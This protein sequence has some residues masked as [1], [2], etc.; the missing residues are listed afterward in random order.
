M[1]FILTFFLTILCLAS[2]LYGFIL[3]VDPYNKFGYNLFGFETKAVDFARQNKFIQVEHSKVPYTAF[4]M[5]SSSAH[6]YLTQ[7]INRLTGLVSYNYSTQSATPEDYISMTR[8]ILTKY[9]PK[10]LLLSMDFEV[11]NKNTK[12]DD[13]FF[14]SPLKKFLSEVPQEDL[15]TD[16]FNNTYFTT[17]AIIDSFKV[18]WVNL[19]GQAN[20][21]YLD[22][23]DHVV[24]PIPKVLKI[25][26]FSFPDYTIDERRV[27]YLKKIVELGAKHGFKVIAFTSPVSYDHIQRLNANPTLKTKHAE[28]KRKLAEIFGEVYD[29]QNEGIKKYNSLQ[30]FRDNNHPTHN[31]ST[32]VLERIFGKEDQENPDFGKLIKK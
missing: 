26:Q 27:D 28:F 9:K 8:H 18:V 23:G 31:F 7:E 3:A 21:A 13:M 6:R 15:K 25:N 32:I 30:F 11:L 16:F 1:K 14:S 19:L 5:G 4:I 17:D 2:S 20:H 29:F 22:N 24:E 10:L 12:T